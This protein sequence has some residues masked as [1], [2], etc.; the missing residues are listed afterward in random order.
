MQVSVERAF[1]A[2]ALTILDQRTSLGENTLEDLLTIKINQ[3]TQIIEVMEW[4]WFNE[5]QGNVQSFFNKQRQ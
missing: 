4:W 2:L 3:P 5:L 1:S